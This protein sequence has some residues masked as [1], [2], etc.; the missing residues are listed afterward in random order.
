MSLLFDAMGALSSKYNETPTTASRPYDEA[1]DGF[2]I[3]GGGGVLVLEDL[4]HAK[5]RG[6]KIYAE[7]T[8]TAQH[9]TVTTWFNH[10]ARAQYVAAAGDGDNQWQQDRLYQRSWYQHPGW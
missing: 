1:R 8:V 2:V 9:P 4:E 10:P 6:A 7:L 3:S 5:A